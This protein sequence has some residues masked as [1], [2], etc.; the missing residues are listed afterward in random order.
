MSVGLITVET[1]SDAVG[2]VLSDLAGN[3]RSDG[4]SADAARFW[5]HDHGT[6][7]PI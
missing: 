5:Q 6:V 3:R 4:V 2:N 7:D 1:S